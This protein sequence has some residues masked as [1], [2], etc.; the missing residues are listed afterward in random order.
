MR[1]FGRSEHCA[2][3]FPFNSKP[4][5]PRFPKGEAEER[6]SAAT[7]RLHPPLVVWGV[8]GPYE[9]SPAVLCILSHR[10]ES[11]IIPACWSI[12]HGLSWAPAPTNTPHCRGRI[13]APAAGDPRSPLH[14]PLAGRFFVCQDLFL[15]PD[16]CP[17][18]SYAQR[19]NWKSVATRRKCLCKPK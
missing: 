12:P 15:H 9:R 18:E 4:R 13:A 11:M 2:S 6:I 3:A 19:K 17:C 5:L 10:R 7:L 8:R 16:F 1:T 14:T